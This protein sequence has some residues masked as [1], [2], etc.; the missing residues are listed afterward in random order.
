[1]KNRH[2]VVERSP[3]ITANQLQRA[4]KF[5][6]PGWGHTGKAF[7]Q[8]RRQNKVRAKNRP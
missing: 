1:M 8:K 3:D 2:T 6:W 5:D 4:A 7:Y